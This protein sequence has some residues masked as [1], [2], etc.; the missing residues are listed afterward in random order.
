ME[1]NLKNYFN[2]D[3]LAESVW[4]GKYALK[5][6]ENNFLEKTPY[7]MHVRMA[8]EIERNEKSFKT[9]L[10]PEIK[11]ELS[12]LGKK[13]LKNLSVEDILPY[14]DKFK[15]IVPQGSIMSGLGD[16]FRIKSL[17]N[18]FV[19]PSPYDS[20]GG[21]FKT[22]QQIAQLEKRR[23]GVGLNINT[24]RPEN[25]IVL[26]AAGTSTGAHSFMERYSNTTREVAQNGRK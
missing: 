16:N 7:D 9:N 11:K 14:F 2:N 5:D 23:G 1:K 10:S 3:D 15:Y 20:Y 22:D 13:L 26:N 12:E 6:L 4:L 21:I 17:S 19:I 18:C 8:K 24:L 25:T